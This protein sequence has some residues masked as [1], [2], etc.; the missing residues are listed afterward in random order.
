M[1][2]VQLTGWQ[3]F[4]VGFLVAAATAMPS[5]PLW[6]YFGAGM[7]LAIAG[8]LMARKGAAG[9]HEDGSAGSGTGCADAE[10]MLASIRK[11]VEELASIGDGGELKERIEALQFGLIADFVAQRRRFAHE[12]GPVRFA[13]FFG[14]FARAE[15]NVNRAWSALV[16]EHRPEVDASL[17][18]AVRSLERS[19]SCL[20]KEDGRA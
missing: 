7:V 3:L 4:F 8:A 18:E 10:V 11:E 16:D 13:R 6:G 20:A 12:Y 17:A 19:I 14:A 2:I 1:N 15:R 9:R 5:P